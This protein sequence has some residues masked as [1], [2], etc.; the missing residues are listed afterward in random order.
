MICPN[1]DGNNA[2][3]AGHYYEC[4]DCGW[5]GAALDGRDHPSRTPELKR[6]DAYRFTRMGARLETENTR[7]YTVAI[8]DDPPNLS[9]EQFGSLGSLARDAWGLGLIAWRSAGVQAGECYQRVIA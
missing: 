3:N 2:K 1:C 5:V 9:P 8:M 4:N 7:Y 6:S